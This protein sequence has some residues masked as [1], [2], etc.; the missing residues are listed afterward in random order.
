MFKKDG[1][2][3]IPECEKFALK[4]DK[5]EENEGKLV[6]REAYCARGHSLMSQVKIDDHSGIQFVYKG[7]ENETEIVISPVVGE[8][9]KVILTGESFGKGEVVTV[10]CPTCRSE[11][12]VLFNCECGAH[13][14]LFYIDRSLENNYGQSFCARIGCARSSR[15]R[16]AKDLLNEFIQEYCF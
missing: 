8:R 6:L 16:F 14:Y 12:P 11:L 10:L 2:L 9:T 13:I 4:G 7:R 1:R 5:V 3:K 15:L